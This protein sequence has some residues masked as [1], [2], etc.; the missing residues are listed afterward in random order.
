MCKSE[1]VWRYWK[2]F[3]YLR[4]QK[5]SSDVHSFFYHSFIHSHSVGQH[6]NTMINESRA[7]CKLSERKI[8]T[9]NKGPAIT[10]LLILLLV[11]WINSRQLTNLQPVDCTFFQTHTSMWNSVWSVRFFTSI[12][13]HSIRLNFLIL[14]FVRFFRLIQWIFLGHCNNRS[15]DTLNQTVI[16]IWVRLKQPNEK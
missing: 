4:V 16:G 5:Y 9:K 3:M 8:E 7:Q 1:C 6:S 14:R 10:K 2:W 12:V 11:G 13:L 15:T